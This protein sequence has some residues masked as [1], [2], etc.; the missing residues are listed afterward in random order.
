[1]PA[2]PTYTSYNTLNIFRQP[3]N[4]TGD[5][6]GQF[7]GTIVFG[8]GASAANVKFDAGRAI[9]FGSN[10]TTAKMIGAGLTTTPGTTTYN[11][12]S[13]ATNAV[14]LFTHASNTTGDMRVI[15]ARLY[16]GGAGGSGE[17]LRAYGIV[18]NVTAA[19]GGTVNGAHITMQVNGASGAVSGAANAI[20]ATF[21]QGASNNAGGTCS[22]IQVDSDLDNAATVA[23]TL[24]YIRFTNSNSKKV[25]NLI[26]L[27]SSIDTTNLYI[28]AGTSA[29]SAG[30][31]THCA[32]QK[33]LRCYDAVNSQYIYIPAFTQ[34]S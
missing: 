1:M 6:A 31:A 33:V 10:T 25:P 27:D 5:N 29:G 4:S 12:G 19:T 20:R 22:V 11:L 17:V 28:A 3:V 26:Y 2:N 24:S 8:A 23:A 9:Q 32:A 21:A 30:N 14:A 16:F 34:N 13:T 15:N 18:N 7:D